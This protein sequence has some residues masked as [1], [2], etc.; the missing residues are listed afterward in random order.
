[1]QLRHSL[2]HSDDILLVIS[3]LNEC[4]WVV[5]VSSHSVL[6]GPFSGA[7]L[8]LGSIGLV[9]VSDFGHERIVRVGVSQQ[10]A[11]RQKHLGDGECRGP[12]VL[13]D[14]KADATI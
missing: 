6:A 13:E 9:D 5:R 10:G 4:A 2:P 3:S 14:I 12:L 8:V 1:L 11:D 7:G